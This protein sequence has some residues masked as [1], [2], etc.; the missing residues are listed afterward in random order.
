M[1]EIFER[2]PQADG[3]ADTEIFAKFKCYCDSNTAKKTAALAIVDPQNMTVA[4]L[5]VAPLK[6]QGT[7]LPPAAPGSAAAAAPGSAKKRQKRE[8]A[9]RQREPSSNE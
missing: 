4:Y 7:S 6:A 3:R 8:R 5:S 1:Q 2:P 9:P